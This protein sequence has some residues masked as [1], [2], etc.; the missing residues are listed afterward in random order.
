MTPISIYLLK[1]LFLISMMIPSCA[2]NPE[3]PRN[4]TPFIFQITANYFFRF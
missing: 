2:E 3:K 4:G 1:A